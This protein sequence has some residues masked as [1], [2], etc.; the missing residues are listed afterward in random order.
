VNSPAVI[1]PFRRFL[2]CRERLHRIAAAKGTVVVP[3]S[4]DLGIQPEV[5]GS[6]AADYAESPRF[7]GNRLVDA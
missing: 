2:E 5:T 1:I 3:A 7:I 6:A 4:A